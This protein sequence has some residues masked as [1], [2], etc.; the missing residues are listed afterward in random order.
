MERAGNERSGNKNLMLPVAAGTKITEGTMVAL[1]ASG[2]AVPADKSPDLRV[3][4]VALTYADNTSGADG[5]QYAL[6]RRGC[7]VLNNDGTI[8][9]TDILKD[10]YVSDETTV[11]I[12]A[13]GS[14]RAGLILGVEEDGV[15]IEF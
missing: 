6:A 4:G 2:Y 14:S 12:T 10:C 15:I 13:D 5:Q 11:T 3:A 1:G 7:F 8:K 9:E